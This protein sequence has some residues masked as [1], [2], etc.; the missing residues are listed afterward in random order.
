[1]IAQLTRPHLVRLGDAR[2]RLGYERIDRHA[3]VAELFVAPAGR[4]RLQQV[5]FAI[6][7][8][9]IW[10]IRLT[11][12]GMIDDRHFSERQFTRLS[13]AS[14]RAMNATRGGS[15]IAGLIVIVGLAAACGGNGSGEEKDSTVASTTTVATAAPTPTARPAPTDA[16]VQQAF[17]AFVKERADDGVM[18]A[19]SV[20]SVKVTGGV[21]TV[22][23]DP[24]PGILE[25]SPFD[26][27]AKL[28]G[29]PVA[30]NDDDGVW[31][32]ETVQRVDVVNA[33]GTSLGSMT[34]AELNKM[35]A[36]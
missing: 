19:Q 6:P 23:V 15:A 26:N 11:C 34:A 13:F 1:M 9:T 20:T 22:A 25:T 36:G 5:V 21:V 31:L 10:R 30:F 32:R 35:G 8:R 17:E 16:Q 12:D 3:A 27:Q 7:P 24:A 2:L 33:D 14:V 29:T 4:E 18:L 28:F